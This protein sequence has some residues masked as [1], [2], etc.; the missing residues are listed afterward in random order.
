MVNLCIIHIEY[1]YSL[2]LFNNEYRRLLI[3]IQERLIEL[4]SY[5][6]KFYIY[7]CEIF[8][9][10]NDNTRVR[11]VFAHTLLYKIISKIDCLRW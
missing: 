9:E 3:L 6:M 11:N 2:C 7:T 4:F 5:L 10:I 1:C 8:T